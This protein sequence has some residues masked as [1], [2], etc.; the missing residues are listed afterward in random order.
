MNGLIISKETQLTRKKGN[1][2]AEKGVLMHEKTNKYG[3]W[4]RRNL[5]FAI[6]CKRTVA[7]HTSGKN[8]EMP[9]DGCS[10]DAS[11]ESS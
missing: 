6:G 4:E 1:G 10:L 5:H 11:S 8:R 9:R 7:N 3:I 2:R